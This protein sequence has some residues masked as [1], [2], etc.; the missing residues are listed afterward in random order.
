MKF[1]RFDFMTAWD[2]VAIIPTIILVWNEQIY[3]NKNFRV[4]IHWLGWHIAWQ[5]METEEWEEE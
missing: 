2:W 5:W 4:S 3:C 1:R